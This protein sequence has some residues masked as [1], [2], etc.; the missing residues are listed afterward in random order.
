[1]NHILFILESKFSDLIN[2]VMTALWAGNQKKFNPGDLKSL[3]G[4]MYDQVK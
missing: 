3:I 4:K 1:M 2:N